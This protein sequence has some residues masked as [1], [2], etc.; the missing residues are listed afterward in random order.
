MARGNALP[1]ACER[2][3]AY[4][5]SL[6]LHPRAGICA[7]LFYRR[8]TEMDS[9]RRVL[10]VQNSFLTASVCE[11]ECGETIARRDDL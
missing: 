5:F 11:R 6:Y 8:R 2:Q 10:F 3:C 1:C 7:P 4:V 9:E